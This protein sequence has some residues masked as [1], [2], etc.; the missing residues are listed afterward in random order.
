MRVCVHASE[1]VIVHLNVEL[2][3]F[4][5]G[6]VC[7][8]DSGGGRHGDFLCSSTMTRLASAV[9]NLHKHICT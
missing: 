3:V 1:C 7:V 6:A 8:S 2:G 9:L 4:T 5:V